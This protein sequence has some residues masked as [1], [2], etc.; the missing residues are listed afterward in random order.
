V[1][2]R[3]LRYFVAVVEEGSLTTAAE[4]RLHTSQPSLSATCVRAEFPS[5]VCH[6]PPP[7]RRRAHD[8]SRHRLQQC[9]HVSDF[10]TVPFKDGRLDCPCVAK[11]PLMRER[12]VDDMRVGGT[13][14]VVWAQACGDRDDGARD[15]EALLLI[16][17]STLTGLLNETYHV[18]YVI[19]EWILIW[20]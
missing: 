12:L 2:L 8:R 4:L 10:E 15:P 20:S 18:F 9:E 7:G 3:H 17:R 11:N 14:V 16:W 6:Q 5:L 13:S 19:C 1:E